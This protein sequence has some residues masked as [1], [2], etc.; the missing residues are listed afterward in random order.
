MRLWWTFFAGLQFAILVLAFNA[1]V[2]GGL[3][4]MARMARG[5]LWTTLS[6]QSFFA[7]RDDHGRLT[8]KMANVGFRLMS[9]ALPNDT[10]PRR[11]LL[12][13]QVNTSEFSTTAGDG[14]VRLDAWVMDSPTDLRRAPLY[15]IIAP[16]RDANLDNDG[17]MMVERGGGRRSAYTLSDG[18]WLFDSDTS[19]ATFAVEGER[20]HYAALAQSDDDMP[21]GAVAIIALTT[22]Q[23]VIRRLMVSVADPIR[24]RFL[25][26]SI[27]MTRPVARM[28]DIRN[29]VLEVPLPAG[30]LRIP[31][32][33]DD[34][35]LTTAEIPPGFKLTE[36]KPWGRKK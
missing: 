32:A 13:L 22:P 28:E 33:G 25:R 14:R 5:E 35:D 26:G 9:I 15:T 7:I 1:P 6:D 2:L 18:S 36:L 30:T 31:I 17:M 24:A 10:R 3:A 16:G 29:R 27:P 12:R 20:R 11:L 21:Q 34:L 23:R 4:L 8:G 19:I